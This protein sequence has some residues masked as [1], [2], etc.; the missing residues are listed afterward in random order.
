MMNVKLNC[1]VQ[2]KLSKDNNEYY[3]L[4]IDE[5]GKQVF[6]SDTEVKLLKLLTS[7]GSIDVI[8]EK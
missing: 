8:E 5:I 1:Q 6:L 4:I 7:N 3:V 2:R